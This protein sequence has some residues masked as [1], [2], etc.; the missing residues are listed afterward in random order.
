MNPNAEQFDDK[1]K[2][3]VKMPTMSN[4]AAFAKEQK[5]AAEEQESKIVIP[6]LTNKPKEPA[7]KP[8]IMEMQGSDKYRPNFDVNHLPADEENPA[9][10]QYVFQVSEE[11]SAKDIEI[12][13]SDTEIK[14]SSANY[15]FNEKFKDFK[16][17][18]STVRAKFSKKK[19]TLT[20]TID[21]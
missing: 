9:K 5:G 18:E 6:G 1:P 13:V 10:I 14:L 15:E 19:G 11:S 4:Q 7:K 8:I 16:V 2:G 12:D 21:K 3:E 20:L 17:D